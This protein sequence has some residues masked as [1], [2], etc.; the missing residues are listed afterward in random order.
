MSMGLMAGS[1]E[2][3]YSYADDA[4]RKAL[5][6]AAT[7]SGLTS[8]RRATIFRGYGAIVAA[9]DKAVEPLQRVVYGS[10][11]A[12]YEGIDMGS[13]NKRRVWLLGEYR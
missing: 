10:Q 7:G 12:L 4:Y 13:Q 3:T 5:Q 1:H 6:E 11:R 2:A 8:E 9:S